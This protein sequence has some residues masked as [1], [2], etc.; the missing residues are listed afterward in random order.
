MWMEILSI[1][2]VV[3]FTTI[4]M[5]GFRAEREVSEEAGPFL[6]EWEIEKK[7]WD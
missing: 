4:A 6:D 3:S 5:W 7:E 1:G 2:L